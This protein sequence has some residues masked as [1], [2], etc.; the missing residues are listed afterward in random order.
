VAGTALI[1][2]FTWHARRRGPAA[3]LDVSLFRRR[4]FATALAYTQAGD[5]TPYVL[6]AVALLVIGLGIGSTIMPCMAAAFQGLPREQ[7]PA[8]TSV[9]NVIQ[10]VSGTIGTALLAVFLQRAIATRAPREHGGLQQMATLPH[11]QHVHLAPALAHA[12]GST[13]WI[14]VGLIAAGLIPAVL[15]PGR[16]RTTTAVPGQRSDPG[17]TVQGERPATNLEG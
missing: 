4:G 6:L 11:G 10:R 1:T 15:L 17:G 7:T 5:R 14:A 8:A 12:F 2:T 13:F 3:L 9:L 16:P